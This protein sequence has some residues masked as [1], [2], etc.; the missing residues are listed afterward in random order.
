M[1]RRA[2]RRNLISFVAVLGLAGLMVHLLWP[3]SPLGEAEAEAGA[4][5]EAKAEA[6][7]RALRGAAER[8][9]AESRGAARL[10]PMQAGLR[11]APA[12]QGVG[13]APPAPQVR[14]AGIP[15]MRPE[16]RGRRARRGR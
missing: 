14:L 13:E 16:R 15:S 9:A 3:V 10:P 12:G 11:A 2:L 5:A 8:I 6:Q 7:R 4:E 1:A